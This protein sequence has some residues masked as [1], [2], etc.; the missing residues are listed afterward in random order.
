MSAVCYLFVDKPVA[1]LQ[2]DLDTS[3]Q[4]T[5][6]I[7]SSLGKL[8]ATGRT[9]DGKLRIIIYGLNQSTFQ[10]HF[11]DVDAPIVGISGVIGSNPDASNVGANVV[12]LSKPTG[13]TA[14]IST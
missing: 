12:M 2:L 10:G 7:D 11:A 6:T 4:A 13:L 5:S 14:S 8:F 3:G 9:L 1:S